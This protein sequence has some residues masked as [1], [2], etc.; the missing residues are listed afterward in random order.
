MN[1]LVFDL[2][3]IPD[4][5]SGGRLYNLEG[6]EAA[7]AAKLMLSKCA[8]D[9][10]R[11]PG[12]L[13]HY[14]QRIVAISVV[15]KSKDGLTLRSLGEPDSAEPELIRRF[16][17]G[18][19][20]YNPTIVSWNGS[21]FDLPVLHYRSLLHGITARH[22]WETGDNQTS[23]RYNN[24]LNRFH[25]RHTDL[26]DVLSGYMPYAKAP[27]ADI[28]A[29]LGLPG[30]MGMSGDKVWDHYQ[31]G[32]IDTIR[33]YCETDVLNTYLIYLRYQLLR[34][35]LDKAAHQDECDQVAE[36]L[37]S[38]HKPHLSEFLDAWQRS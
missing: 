36:I 11:D 6:L 34:G 32:G 19:E 33:N 10:V 31:Q 4:I 16:F 22:Y 5:E 27:L 24:Y 23:F 29:I 9:D 12:F 21:G 25:S 28:A 17:E 7:D 2:E 14:L 37:K 35:R 18:I 20:H 30:K 1:T 3:T 13:R 15:L 8:R 38:E 26:M